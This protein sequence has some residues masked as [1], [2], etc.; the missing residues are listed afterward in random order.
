M[1]EWAP[2]IP[3]LYETQ[4]EAPNMINEYELNVQD[5]SIN[6]D[7]NRQDEYG[8]EQGLNII[9][10][11]QYPLNEEG[12]YITEEEDNNEFDNTNKENNEYNNVIIETNY[13][14]S[15]AEEND[16]GED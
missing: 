5:V 9:E 10:E 11:N 3:I 8:D 7:Y 4:E 6:D 14:I 1:F 12:I 13:G 15:A 2:G 16:S